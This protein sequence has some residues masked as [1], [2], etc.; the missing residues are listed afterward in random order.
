MECYVE[1]ANTAQVSE[2]ARRSVQETARNLRYDFLKKLRTSLG[3]QKIA[4]AHHANDN[5]ETMLLN[6]FRGAGIHGL[7]GIPA[8]RNDIAV[9]RPLLF[10][11]R[12]D[13]AA[14]ARERC[15]DHREDSSNMKTEYTRNFLRHNL[16]PLLQENINPNLIATL[17][18]TS[19]VFDH[20]ERYVRC[21]VATILPALILRQS[22]SE[23]VVNLTSMQEKPLFLQEYVLLHLAREFTNIEI[24]LSTARAML[25]VSRSDT[26]AAVSLT[27]D[28]VCYR[29]RDELLLKRKC[30]TGPYRHR[31]E[32]N[33]PYDFEHFHFS[34]STVATAEFSNDP[35]SE[36]VDGSLLGEELSVRTW[37]EGDTFRPLGMKG[38]KKLSDFF[39]DEKIPL[40]EKQSI[41]I[42]VSDGCIVWICG[43][44]LDDRYKL[45]PRTTTI[46]RLDYHPR[47]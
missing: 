8:W 16:I 42:L 40:P 10:T 39:V 13:I 44:R 28:A 2:T 37:K 45:T 25:D 19:E 1:R 41:P 30:P 15:L 46:V 35:D 36:Y 3:F 9:I 23:V 12:D 5:A 24:D 17:R 14:Y 27:K 20:L 29:N 33:T 18:R 34:S 11:T 38:E 26:G 22:S 6:F 21:E 31:I 4:T 7:S 47:S 32:L 43:K